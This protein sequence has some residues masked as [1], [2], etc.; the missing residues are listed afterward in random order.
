MSATRSRSE[1]LLEFDESESGFAEVPE[2]PSEFTLRAVVDEDRDELACVLLDGYRGSV[3]DEGEVLADA[4]EAIDE[5]FS[6]MKWQH[7]WALE[8][9]NGIAAFAFVVVVG[10]RHYIDPLV[11][12]PEFKRRGL[13]AKVVRAALRSLKAEGVRDVGAAITDGNIP[14]ER[15]F[16]SLGFKRIGS[17][18]RQS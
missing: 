12:S 18:P 5:Y 16:A 7:G 3:D 17:W 6:I 15:L 4:V 14:S 1:Y 11:T 2:V 8:S 9:A 13:A 10:D